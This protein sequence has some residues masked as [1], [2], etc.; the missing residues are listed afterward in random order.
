VNVVRSRPAGARHPRAHRLRRALA[1]ACALALVVGLASCGDDG[2]SS[3]G[4]TGVTVMLNWS[5]NVQH[6]GLYVALQ[7]GWFRDL[8]Y[9]VRI[10]EPGEA[11][12][13]QAVAS[14][15][16]VLGISEAEGVLPARAQGIPI[17][18]VAAILPVNDSSLMALASSGITR[19]RDLAGK[20]YGGYG[21]P[22]ETELIH[23]LVACD[24]GDPD[25]VKQVE[26][27]DADYLAGEQ[28]GRFD[29]VWVFDGW[30][31]QRARLA[32]A[33]VTTIDFS[34]WSDCIPNWYTPV[35]IANEQE[36]ADHP[37][38]VSDLLGAIARGYQAAA[39]D[40]DAAAADFE[41]AVP[42]ADHALVEASARYYADKWHLPGQAWGV[43][44]LATWQGFADFL[45]RAGGLDHPVD[46]SAAFTD[47]ALPAP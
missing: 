37:E 24:G 33:D 34:A 10:L 20:V 9:D 16:A 30:D 26:V 27:G 31:V 11:G 17:R 45:Q 39:D 38:V 41:A 36:L 43:Q 46:P 32:G 44:D 13:E 4:R 29:V 1:A 2:G 22:L 7:R 18:S 42:E 40:P 15:Q 6:I 23:S 25:A 47:Q 19:P 3:S 5:P 35:W 8:G 14:G 28:Q 12:A 21:G